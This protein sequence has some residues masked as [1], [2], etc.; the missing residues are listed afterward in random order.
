MLLFHMADGSRMVVRGSGTEPKIKFYFL[1]RADAKGDLA[2]IKARAQGVP[3]RVV[4][5]SAGGCEEA[6]GVAAAG[7]A[8]I[9]VKSPL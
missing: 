6:S 9:S 4:E 8:I 5:R 2:A 3:R 7:E 1:T